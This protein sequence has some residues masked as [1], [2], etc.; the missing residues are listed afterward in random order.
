MGMSPDIQRRE[1]DLRSSALSRGLG[2]VGSALGQG[3]VSSIEQDFLGPPAATK[4][5]D[6][7][8]KRLERQAADLYPYIRARLRAELVRDRE[9][10]GRITRDWS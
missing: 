2:A 5:K 7:R 1:R 3:L 10:R 6:S 4:D 9:R 8:Y